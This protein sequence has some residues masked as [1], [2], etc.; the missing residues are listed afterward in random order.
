VGQTLSWFRFD[1]LAAGSCC[2]TRQRT[3]D[4]ESYFDDPTL[5]DGFVVEPM[6]ERLGKSK[7]FSKFFVTITTPT[8]AHSDHTPW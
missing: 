7:L 8:V 6:R 4:G 5:A 1:F 2:R 3:P